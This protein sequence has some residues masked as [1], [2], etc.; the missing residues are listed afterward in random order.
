MKT[1]GMD[2]YLGN[3]SYYED[4]LREVNEST[5]KSE[6][7]SKTKLSKEKKSRS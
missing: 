3:Y 2:E 6:T 7:L 4:K 1:N 5:N